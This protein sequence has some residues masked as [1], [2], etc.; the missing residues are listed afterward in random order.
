MTTWRDAG[1]VGQGL[2]QLRVELRL[3][4]DGL[5]A[6]RLDLL[7]ERGEVGRRRLLA[8][9]GED[10]ADELEAEVPREVRER[11]VERDELAVRRRDRGDLGLQLRVERVELRRVG[12]GVR[13]ERRLLG[14]VE[15]PSSCAAIAGR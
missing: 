5:D 14:R 4:E 15:L 2:G 12:R 1:L 10:D 9:V 13:V 3:A 6:G 11:V 8:D 7:D